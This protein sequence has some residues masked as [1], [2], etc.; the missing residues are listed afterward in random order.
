LKAIAPE[1]LAMLVQ[2]ASTG[3]H[4]YPE[5]TMHTRVLAFFFL[6]LV[7][8][9]QA[10]AQTGVFNGPPRYFV[11]SNVVAIAVGDFNGDGNLDLAVANG[12]TESTCGNGSPGVISI[13]LGNG[14]GTFK[15]AVNYSVGN[16]PVS[17]A[18][19]DLNGDGKLDLAVVSYWSNSLSILLGNGDGTFQ[20]QVQYATGPAQNRWQWATS[21]AMGMRT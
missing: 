21:P 15:A 7:F 20:P 18:V 19:A 9:I 17:I 6:V 4:R 3:E 11:A 2:A 16:D 1:A 5:V 8:E 14:D 13:L 12:C 10:S